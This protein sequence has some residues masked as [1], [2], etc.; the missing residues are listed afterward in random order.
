MG[1]PLL[2]LAVSYALED[3]I[4]LPPETL[5][6]IRSVVDRYINGTLEFRDAT[7]TL[8]TAIGPNHIIGRIDQILRTPLTPIPS[9]IG[10]A[11]AADPFSRAKARPWTPYEDQ[12]L[13][14]GI[15]R[16]GFGSWLSVAEFVG[17]DR[18]KAQCYQ[19]WMRG[20][21]P[22]INKDKWTPEQDFQLLVLVALHGNKAWSKISAGIP[23]RCDVQCR[24]RFKQ[25]LKEPHFQELFARAKAASA[26]S[27]APAPFFPPPPIQVVP[28]CPA[29]PLFCPDLSMPPPL[30]YVAYAQPVFMGPLP[31]FP[32]L[33]PRVSSGVF[34][35]PVGEPMPR[36]QIRETGSMPIQ[37]FLPLDKT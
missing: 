34:P 20:L 25:L 21:D 24:Y 6:I 19:R 23:D 10:E 33:L 36:A 3:R 26:A 31:P 12:R 7:L 37:K 30:Q 1:D 14:A 16:F 32:S 35:P 9:M 18:T 4:P 29:P 27:V 2:D 17:N 28:V 11:P 8:S 13:I 15:H 5:M 22:N